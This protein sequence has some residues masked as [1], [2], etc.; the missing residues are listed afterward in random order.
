MNFGVH[1]VIPDK[2]FNLCN[3]SFLVCEMGMIILV[4]LNLVN[5]REG[6]HTG[7]AHGAC[8]RG[9]RGTAVIMMVIV[10]IPPP[11]T[12]VGL[13]PGMRDVRAQSCRVT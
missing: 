2:F 13:S 6:F 11:P 9:G 10:I 7:P 1:C 5:T 8:S 3:L 12:C 4:M